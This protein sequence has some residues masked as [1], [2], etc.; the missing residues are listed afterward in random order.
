M[1]AFLSVLSLVGAGFMSSFGIT[2]LLF[3]KTKMER[4]LFEGSLLLYPVFVVLSHTCFGYFR[5]ES[6]P[7]WTAAAFVSAGALISG[8]VLVKA[9][10]NIVD[11]AKKNYRP[12]SL[13]LFFSISSAGFLLLYFHKDV[14]EYFPFLSNGEY[15][16]YSLLASALMG[17]YP[18][19]DAQPW[20]ITHRGTR[21]G[22]DIFIVHASQLLGL[23]PWSVSLVASAFFR[24]LSDLVLF[25]LLWE[26]IG[27]RDRLFKKSLFLLLAVFEIFFPPNMISFSSSFLSSIASLFLLLPY[28]YFLQTF[29]GLTWRVLLLFLSANVYLLMTYPEFWPF[30]KIAEAIVW[31]SKWRRK[32]EWFPQFKWLIQLNTV[33]LFLHP[34]LIREKVSHIW[35]Q[36]RINAGWNFLGEPSPD[37]MGYLGSLLGLRHPYLSSEPL[38]NKDWFPFSLLLLCVYC[39]GCTFQV[40]RSGHRLLVWALAWLGLLTFFHL[41]P[42]FAGNPNYY[43]AT[44]F[45]IQTTNV[46]LLILCAAILQQKNLLRR[47][48]FLFP[49]LVWVLFLFSA[50]FKIFRLLPEKT[51]YYPCAQIEQDLHPAAKNGRVACLTRK[52]EFL[53][54]SQLLAGSENLEIFA[55]TADQASW[56]ARGPHASPPVYR[57]QEIFQGLIILDN[58]VMEGTGVKELQKFIPL[59]DMMG[60]SFDISPS[61]I[62][63]SREKYTI[64]EG[65]IQISSR[66]SFP[67]A[68][69]VTDEREVGLFLSG[70]QLRVRGSIP[71]NVG[72]KFPYRFTLQIGDRILGHFS[73]PQPGFFSASINLEDR[74]LNQFAKIRLVSPQKFVPQKIDHSS[75]DWRE[76]S[77]TLSEVLSF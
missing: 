65:R 4:F 50:N 10:K 60:L 46:L 42:F 36:L 58:R 7:G 43:G 56:L 51:F 35:G 31:A 12:F 57:T 40:L 72:Y 25:R 19:A 16:N 75:P 62:L 70:P 14:T 39:L 66:A 69:W 2:Y 76:L 33:L 22:V 21:I 59:H 26:W 6:L 17:K 55:L 20:I 45:Y 63:V 24:F 15:L 34:F 61:H 41:L 9:R 77:F 48:I 53:W 68:D 32:A 29:A 13:S 1:I 71:G 23:A 28:V 38:L 49:L 18:F 64:L 37:W 73:I 52:A 5:P 3:Q 8:I 54:A 27:D 47:A 30:F 11:I 67:N 74:Y 44:K